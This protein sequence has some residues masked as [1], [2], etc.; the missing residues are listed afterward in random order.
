MIPFDVISKRSSK[1]RT[2]YAVS[3]HELPYFL[4]YRGGEWIWE[5]S[6]WYEPTADTAEGRWKG[7]GMGD[8][9]CSIE[10]NPDYF[11]DAVGYLR[12]EEVEVEQPS[13]FDLLEQEGA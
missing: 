13:L 2:V 4:I 11:Q 3:F 10:L 9:R 12:A 7:A 6:R 8:Y 5:E 1:K